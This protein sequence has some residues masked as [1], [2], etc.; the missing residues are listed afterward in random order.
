MIFSQLRQERRELYRNREKLKKKDGIAYETAMLIIRNALAMG[1]GHRVR[2]HSSV[3]ATAKHLSALQRAG[4][5][6]TAMRKL[7][8]ILYGHPKYLK[9]VWPELIRG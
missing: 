5:I 6:D 9:P 1:K 3:W 8:W 2:R 4:H 7:K